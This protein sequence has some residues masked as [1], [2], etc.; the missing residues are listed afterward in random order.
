MND[1]LI[2]DKQGTPRDWAS[3]ET[4]ACYHAR[5]KVIWEIGSKIATFRGGHDKNGDQSIIE[6]SSILGVSGPIFGDE[7]YSRETVYADRAV[8]YKRDRHICAYCGEQFTDRHLTID[9]VLPKSRG[10][11]NTWV[12]TVSACKPCNSAK[13]DR[14]PEEAKM[15]LLYVP[16]APNLFEKMLL[17]NRTILADQMDYLMARVPKTSRAWLDYKKDLN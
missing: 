17:K 6:V 3:P 12:N 13:A 11:K 5:G 7:F 2:V 1:V 9:H 4:G 14:T 10:G 16:Y 15:H 8:L